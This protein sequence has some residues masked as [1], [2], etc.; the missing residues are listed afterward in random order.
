MSHENKLGRSDP[1]FPPFPPTHASPRSGPGPGRWRRQTRPPRGRLQ[2]LWRGASRRAYRRRRRTAA[3]ECTAAAHGQG[4][5]EAMAGDT[6]I[7]RPAARWRA[8]GRSR[9]LG[10][11]TPVMI[12][13]E[14]L[15]EPL[16]RNRDATRPTAAAGRLGATRTA[17][18]HANPG[19][20][21]PAVLA[22][23][24][25]PHCA[26]AAAAA[27]RRRLGR[28]HQK[29]GKFL[30]R[31]EEGFGGRPRSLD[32]DAA[33]LLQIERGVKESSILGRG[34]ASGC[35][36]G[37][38]AAVR[39][40]THRGIARGRIGTLRASGCWVWAARRAATH[41][42]ARRRAWRH[43]PAAPALTPLVFAVHRGRPSRVGHI[44]AARRPRSEPH[45]AGGMGLWQGRGRRADAAYD[46]SWWRRDQGRRRRR[47]PMRAA[48][49][50][51]WR[52][53][54]GGAGRAGGIGG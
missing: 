50:F 14:V 31:V 43:T 13:R 42:V 34:L 6:G 8:A 38:R 9:G 33:R 4:A 24:R 47:R 40:M 35:S 46:S 5:V 49:C 51:R 3:H 17:P 37:G 52:V 18:A 2:R 19:R 36:A 15:L 1:S 28:A 20:S 21:V 41:G 25:A 39:R 12:H 23:R 45:A 29:N 16:A 7:A 54:G 32:V 27:S 30:G 11:R 10:G 26:A 53:G 22:P 48:R 44:G